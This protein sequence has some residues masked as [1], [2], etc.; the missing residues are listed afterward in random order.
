VAPQVKNVKRRCKNFFKKVLTLDKEM[1]HCIQHMKMTY[2]VVVDNKGTKRWYH[3]DK[4]HRTDGPA[5]ECADGT[6]YWYVNGEHHRLDGPAVENA[7]GHK[8]WYRNGKLHRT[9][10][11]AVEWADGTKYWYVDGK[12]HRTDGPAIEYVDGSKYWFLDGEE[13]TE[14]QWRKRVTKPNCEGK[15]VEVDGVQY[16]L[17]AL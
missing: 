15:V 5:I 14:A 13:L 12:L 1:I 8:E 11:P 17:V 6:K 9:D 2:T 10:G 4:L 7:D 3:N 16:K